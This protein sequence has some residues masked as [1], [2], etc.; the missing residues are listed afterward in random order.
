MSYGSAV[1]VA[2]LTPLWTDAGA[3]TASTNPTLAQV[4]VWIGEISNT[5]DIVLADEGFVVPITVASAVSSLDLLVNGWVKDLVE[6]SR[7]AGRFYSKKTLDEGLSPMLV[8]DKEIHEWV[9]RKSFGLRNLGV[10]M[11]TTGAGR[12]LASFDVLG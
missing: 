2:A 11:N 3:F 4:N 6:H 12:H 5:L 1:G 9:A 7:K 10:P 8:I